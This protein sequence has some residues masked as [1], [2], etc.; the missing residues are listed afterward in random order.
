MQ[1]QSTNLETDAD[2][3]I[4]N[5]GYLGGTNFPGIVQ[6]GIVGLGANP[7]AVGGGLNLGYVGGTITL[8]GSDTPVAPTHSDL[9]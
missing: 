9:V 2:G 5:S 7:G 1:W 6:P 8:P 3:N 4:T